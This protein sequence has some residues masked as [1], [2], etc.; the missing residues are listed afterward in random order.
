[1]VLTRPNLLKNAHQIE[2]V[3]VLSLCCLLQR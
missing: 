3:E 2:C 1:M